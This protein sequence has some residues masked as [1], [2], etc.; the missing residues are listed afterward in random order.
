MG[1]R[2]GGGVARGDGLAED[3]GCIGDTT[4]EDTGSSSRSATPDREVVGALEGGGGVVWV[5]RRPLDELRGEPDPVEVVVLEWWPI[6]RI[7]E[8]A[9]SMSSG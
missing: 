8:P 4:I 9:L 2:R 5:E 3:E 1:S 6:S 7:K